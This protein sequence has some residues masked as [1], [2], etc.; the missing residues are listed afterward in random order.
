MT[1]QE[2]RYFVAVAETGHFARAAERCHVSQP[3]LSTQLKK[4]EGYLGVKLFDRSLRRVTPTPVGREILRA[5]RAIVEEAERIRALARDQGKGTIESLRLGAIATVSPYYLPHAI[6][7]LRRAFPGLKL[8]LREGLTA[9]LLGELGSGALDAALVALPVE[10]DALEI[11]PLFEEPFVAALPRGHPLAAKRTLD[12]GDLAGAGVLLLEEGHCL[13]EQALEVCGAAGA[14]SEELKATSLETLAHMVAGGVA[15]TLLPMLA[16][17]P[18]G[19]RGAARLEIRRFRA[20]APRRTVGLVWRLRYAYGETLR[21]IAQRLRDN[22]PE[23]VTAARTPPGR[24]RQRPAL[25][26]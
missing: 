21:E 1:L 13:R 18:Q 24:D 7:V 5:A 17:G 12:P 3:T 11:E 20:P 10:A 23:G 2:L 16:A 25:L 19:V 8:L 26:S 14:A 22:L 6:G 4:L 15:C 9:G